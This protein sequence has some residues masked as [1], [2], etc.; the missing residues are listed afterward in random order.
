MAPDDFVA[1]DQTPD[2]RKTCGAK[3]SVSRANGLPVLLNRIR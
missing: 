2:H 1:G 3:R